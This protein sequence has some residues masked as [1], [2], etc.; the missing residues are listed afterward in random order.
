MAKILVKDTE[1]TILEIDEKDY[2]SITD[3]VKGIE[4]WLALIENGCETKTP[5]NF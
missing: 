4:N 5:S 1:I 2:I 3:M